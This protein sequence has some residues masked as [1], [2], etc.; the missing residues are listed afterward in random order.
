MKPCKLTTKYQATIPKE[1][2]TALGIE[3]GDSII[4]QIGQDGIVT[5]KKVKPFDKS[6]LEA[7]GYTLS[8]WDSKEDDDAFANLQNL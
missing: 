1:V 5:L 3:S 6:Y 2:R 7:V 4:F 8:E